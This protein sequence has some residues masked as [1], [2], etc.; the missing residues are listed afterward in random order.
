MLEIDM[1]PPHSSR[2][3]IIGTQGGP[4]CGMPAT[5]ITATSIPPAH[6][7]TSRRSV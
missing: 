3:Q 7:Q 4:S 1:Y 2:K 5:S 6:S